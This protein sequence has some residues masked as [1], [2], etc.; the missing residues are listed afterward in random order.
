MPEIVVTGAEGMLGR[1]WTTLLKARGADFVALGRD[2][3][4][5]TDAASIDSAVELSTRWVINCAAYTDVDGAE[6]NPERADAVNGAAVGSLARRCGR[7][8]AKLVHY[9]TDYVFDGRARSPYPTDHPRAPVNAYGR[10]KALGESLLEA[11]QVDYLLIRSSW[12]YA[13]WGKNFVLTMRGLVQ[14]RPALRVVDD[15]RGRPSSCEH[16]AG[17]TI[18]LL[19]REA[20]GIHHVCDGGE[21]TWYELA[22]AIR[23]V[24]NPACEIEPCTTEEFPRPATR[25]AYSVLA[26]DEAEAILGPFGSWQDRVAAVLASCGSEG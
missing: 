5:I 4:D 24:V 23:D 2:A 9:S 21:C 10:S 13:P 11:S 20:A 22:C 12:L 25:P 17:A 14:S 6:S 26:L 1:A 19:E 15:Q 16:I 18:A 7:V 8:G 3:L